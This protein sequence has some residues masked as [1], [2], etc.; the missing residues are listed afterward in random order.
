MIAENLFIVGIW[1]SFMQTS[2]LGLFVWLFFFFCKDWTSKWPNVSD[3]AKK[4]KR[5]KADAIYACGFV[6]WDLAIFFTGVARRM[7]SKPQDDSCWA[8][9]QMQGLIQNPVK[10]ISYMP[11]SWKRKDIMQP[12]WGLAAL[13][14]R[15]NVI[16]QSL[17]KLAFCCSGLLPTHHSARPPERI[18]PPMGLTAAS[19]RQ[20]RSWHRRHVWK[21]EREDPPQICERRWDGNTNRGEYPSMC[22]VGIDVRMSWQALGALPSYPS[23]R[24]NTLLPCFEHMVHQ[25]RHLATLT[26][27]SCASSSPVGSLGTATSSTTCGSSRVKKASD[28]LFCSCSCK[29]DFHPRDSL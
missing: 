10:G 2:V 19:R 18:S 17:Q 28:E 8:A 25:R 1:I 7:E 14:L 16:I 15:R 13:V 21:R 6:H 27:G 9:G 24:T 5:K 4:Q 23:S 22:Q 29:L 26:P 20:H 12:P 11:V 3:E